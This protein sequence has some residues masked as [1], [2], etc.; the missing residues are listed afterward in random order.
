MDFLLTE[1]IVERKVRGLIGQ[2]DLR[3]IGPDHQLDQGKSVTAFHERDGKS[4]DETE[5]QSTGHR[6]PFAAEN[7]FRHLEPPWNFL[8]PEF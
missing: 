2:H 3:D 6:E 4:Q 7:S 1:C 8:T 5:H